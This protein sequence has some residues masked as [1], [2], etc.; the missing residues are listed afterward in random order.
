MDNNDPNVPKF[1]LSAFERETLE[2]LVVHL[3]QVDRIR[4]G[5]NAELARRLDATPGDAHQV[6]SDFFAVNLELS[7]RSDA[8]ISRIIAGASPE[9]VAN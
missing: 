7:A 5:A 8:E 2:R 1:D 4:D 9:K 6:F 3:M